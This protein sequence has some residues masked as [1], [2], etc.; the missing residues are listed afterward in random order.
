M[1]SHC[2]SFH[3]YLH[4]YTI[5]LITYIYIYILFRNSFSNYPIFSPIIIKNS[6]GDHKKKV[7]RRGLLLE[8]DKQKLELVGQIGKLLVLEDRA[9]EEG[10]YGSQD[11]LIADPSSNESG[12]IQY[13]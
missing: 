13:K 3:F 11:L 10:R 8:G 12:S 2:C 6:R 5:D 9:I 4:V 1:I 7:L